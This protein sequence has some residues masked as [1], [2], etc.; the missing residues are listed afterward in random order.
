[1]RKILQTTMMLI[2]AIALIAMT[3]TTNNPDDQFLYSGTCLLVL[4]VTA[5]IAASLEP[6]KK[7]VCDE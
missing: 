4:V 1:M 2:G 3:G 7:E 6:K 5:K